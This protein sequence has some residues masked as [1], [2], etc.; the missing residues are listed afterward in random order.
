MTTHAKLA[1]TIDAAFE[2]R[3][4]LSPANAPRRSSRRRRRPPSSLLDSGEA[5][6]AEKVGGGWVVNQWL[7]KAVLLHF[8]R[9]DN[10]V[11]DAGDTRFY[12]KVPLKHAGHDAERFRA[13]GARVVPA[14]I[15]RRGAYVARECGAD[16]LLRQHRRLRRRGHDGGHL[17]DG[18]LLRADRP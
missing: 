13:E 14:A 2:E 3:A 8:A 9:N 15:V 1:A 11:I 18:R 6:V 4:K 7:K 16:A 17:G 10:R 5:R 12:D